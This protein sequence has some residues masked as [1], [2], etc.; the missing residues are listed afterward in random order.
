MT[1][2]TLLPLTKRQRAVWRWIRDYHDRNRHGCSVR[3]LCQQFG[4]KSTN[5]VMCH[6]KA[7]IRKGWL[8]WPCTM[9]GTS[10]MA[11]SIIPTLDSLEV[12]DE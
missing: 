1:T 5:G 8:E 2:T 10:R 4:I 3:D 12:C 7:L 9:S 6:L 11:R